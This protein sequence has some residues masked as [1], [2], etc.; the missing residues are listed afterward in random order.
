M[1]PEPFYGDLGFQGSL[2]ES[3]LGPG[4]ESGGGWGGDAPWAMIGQCNGEFRL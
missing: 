4:M 2:G 1:V 3:K